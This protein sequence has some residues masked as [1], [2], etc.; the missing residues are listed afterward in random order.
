VKVKGLLEELIGFNKILG[1]KIDYAGNTVNGIHIFTM[2][3]WSEL[4]AD[5]M[6]SAKDQDTREIVRFCK[7]VIW[8]PYTPLITKAE[9]DKCKSKPDLATIYGTILCIGTSEFAPKLEVFK[10]LGKAL[11]DYDPQAGLD[12]SSFEVAITIPSGLRK[13]EKAKRV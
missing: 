2:G 1:K 8:N 7:G 6:T 11:I 3:P 5:T 9:Y 4:I 13:F 10:K 12:T